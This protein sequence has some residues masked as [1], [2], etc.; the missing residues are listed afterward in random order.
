M[1]DD[2]IADLKQFIATTVRQ[3][4]TGLEDRLSAK[5]DSLQA[6]VAEALDTGNDDVDERLHGLELRVDRLEHRAA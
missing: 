6:S 2:T 1:N 4:M 5:I 3:E